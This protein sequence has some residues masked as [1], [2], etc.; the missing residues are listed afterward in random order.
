ME[1]LK[2]APAANGKRN[3][4]EIWEPR[5]FSRFRKNQESVFIYMLTECLYRNTLIFNILFPFYLNVKRICRERG[6]A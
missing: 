3:M 2:T 1:A 5:S 6:I 4:Y